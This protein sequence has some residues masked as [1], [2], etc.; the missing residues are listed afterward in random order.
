M[1]RRVLLPAV[2]YL[3]FVYPANG[4]RTLTVGQG[5]G[6]AYSTIQSAIN[7]ATDGDMVIVAEGT[8]VENI[9]YDGK[10]IV[11]TSTNPGDPPTV[12]ATIIDGN[13]TGPVV[14]LLGTESDRAALLGFTIRNG[15]AMPPFA[16]GGG[17]R[18]GNANARIAYNV[19]TG[20]SAELG[21]GIHQCRGVI[22]YNTISNNHVSGSSTGKGGGLYDCDGII[23]ENSILS[24]TGPW[25]YGGGL[26]GCDGW[27]EN[28]TIQGNSSSWLGGGL[29]NCNGTILNN[30]ISGNQAELGGGLHS[31]GGIIKSNEILG[32][33]AQE[34]GGLSRCRGMI[35]ENLIIYNRANGAGATG[36]GL[37]K[38]DGNLIRNNTIADNS[39]VAR[40][41]GLAE[42]HATSIVN[43]IV[44]RNTA[45]AEPQI[46]DCT[47][48]TYSCI[49]GWMA[50]GRGNTNLDPLFVRGLWG[51][52]YLSQIAAGQ[53]VQSPCVDTGLGTVLDWG[54]LDGTTRTDGVP[55]AGIIDMGY[56][57][58]PGALVFPP[59]I[60]TRPTS[61]NLTIVAGTQAATQTL[62][63]RNSGG[64][65]LFYSVGPTVA[66]IRGVQPNSGSS[67]GSWNLHYVSFDTALLAPGV[68]LGEIVV[69]GN[70]SNSPRIVPVRLTVTRVI[71]P[72][73]AVK[74]TSFFLFVFEGQTTVTQTLD[75]WNNDGGVLNYT[76]ATSPTWL[77]DV[78]PRTGQSSGTTNTHTVVFQ[79]PWLPA[80]RYLGQIV[81]T[82]NAI[83][84]P[85]TIPIEVIVGQTPPA[86]QIT[87]LGFDILTTA[88]VAVP[89]Q[90]LGIKNVGG[91]AAGYMILASPT[92][93]IGVWPTTGTLAPDEATT[94]DVI[95]DTLAL[96][97][98]VYDGFVAIAA[99]TS[100]SLYFLFAR[101]TVTTA[102]LPNL[103]ATHAGI[104]PV[105]P[106]ELRPGSAL[107]LSARV[108]NIGAANADPFWMELWGSRT[109]GLTIDRFLATSLYLDG[110]LRRGGTYSWLTSSPL[111]GI[112]DGPYTVVYAAD[113]PG[114]IRETNERDNR[115]VVRAKRILVIRP[116][117]Q[118]DLAVEGFSMRPNP[119]RGGQSVTFSGRVVNRGSERSGPFWI[120]FWGAR[121]QFYPELDFFLCDSI[122]VTNL[123]PNAAVNLSAYPRR[124][125]GVTTGTFTIGCFADRDDAINET[126]ETNNYEFVK[127]QVFN[128]PSRTEPA[129]FIP[130]LPAAD[131][132]IAAADFSPA[133]PTRVAPGQP[134]TFDVDLTNR[135]TDA[136]RN[137]WLEYWG[138]RDG[139]VTLCDFIAASDAIAVLGPGATIHRSTV[140]RLTGVP[141]GPY[142]VVVVADRPA[143]VA[144]SDE[145]N[146]RRAVGGKRLLAIRPPTAVNLVVEQFGVTHVSRVGV[147]FTGRVR[148]AGTAMSGPFWMEFWACPGDE[149]YPG[150]ERFVCDSIQVDHLQPGDTVDL[151]YRYMYGSVPAGEHTLIGFVDRLDQVMETDE[152]DN[153]QLVRRVVVP[154]R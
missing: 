151:S 96:R 14:V 132:Y 43:C 10:S 80:G 31:C 87:P 51:A 98:S 45:A 83:N 23:R 77:A 152:T 120:E 126:D 131:L 91:S 55:D 13:Q 146:N 37:S 122:F 66:W 93:M 44:W 102:P 36:G 105:G 29:Y 100:P 5:P 17:I 116:P 81:V 7:A 88:G 11:V 79:T 142:T 89:V 65:T 85:T 95:F 57:Y 134:I 19:V 20:N 52:Y 39:A 97:P 138:S 40:G 60:E 114:E 58:G 101:V 69:S 136:A 124:L 103:I 141:D 49:Q 94:H 121:P 108:E 4:Q 149:D 54:V 150:L 41:G 119:A 74:P 22:E 148:N 53:T 72:E 12:G 129:P 117:T 16:Q 107:A 112:P 127:G 24:H 38:C 50:G 33:T 125:Y 133:A 78:T 3:F 34:G 115:A 47:A 123:D 92:T 139:G 140:K 18:G 71:A 9:H 75:V 130:P 111:L 2:L 32:N 56:H 27:I 26:N 63:I 48:P 128:G 145:T 21:G 84:S 99:N 35:E 154:A 76:I 59:V 135:G 144:E 118:I 42:C 73:I 62:E 86:L 82:G 113:R 6:Y 30:T 153:Y 109:G 64:G 1:A 104:A 15:R 106:V 143:T 67:T 8:Y 25:E 90:R 68:Y 46:A 110:G 28:N 61:Y 137:F 70:A 147:L